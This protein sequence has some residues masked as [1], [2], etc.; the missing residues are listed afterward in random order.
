MVRSIPRRCGAALLATAVTGLLAVVDP[1]PAAAVVTAGDV[2]D[3][4]IYIFEADRQE[5]IR[6]GPDGT[7]AIIGTGLLNS[8]GQ[9]FDVGPDGAVYSTATNFNR[10]ETLAPNGTTVPVP[11]V[12]ALTS[13]QSVGVDD[14]GAVYVTR[15]GNGTVVKRAADGTES[16]FSLPVALAFDAAV[17]GDGS[18]YMINRFN[19]SLVM[20]TPSGVVS[21]VA[22][23]AQIPNASAVAV[24]DGGVIYLGAYTGQIYRVTLGAGPTTFE[25]LATGLGY[26]NDISVTGDGHVYASRDADDVVE[27]NGDGSVTQVLTGFDRPVGLVVR[28]VPS[29][30]SS[31]TATPGSAS[32]DVSWD[33]GQTNGGRPIVRYTAVSDPGGLTCTPL[34]PTDT[35]CTVTGLT[36]GVQY[37]FKVTASNTMTTAGESLLSGASNAVTPGLPEA[38]T[39]FQATPGDTTADVSFVPGSPGGD[40][41]QTWET[42]ID[43]EVSWQPLVTQPGAGGTLTG[44]VSS[45]P[46]GVTSTILLRGRTSIGPGPAATTTVI[47]TSPSPSPSP[48][49]TSPSPS[50]SSTSPSPSP[51]TTSP[52]TTPPT[53]TPPT[54]TPPTTQPPTTAP[55]TTP[56]PTTPPTTAP[57]T[58]PPTS[59]TPTPT[60]STPAPTRPNAPTGVTA[61]AGTSSVL[62]SWQPPADNGV[63]ITGYRAV[64]VPGPASCTTNGATSCILGGTA[65]VSYRVMVVAT[66]ASGNS[67]AS[68]YSNTAIPTA[69]TVATTPPA[70]NVPLDTDQGQITT[71]TPGQSLTLVGSGYAPYS[72]VT[73]T[74]YSEPIVLATV[75]TDKNGAFSQAVTVPADLASGKHSF[76]ATGVNP[77]GKPR[78]MRMDV[79]VQHEPSNLP[80]TGSAV[81]W[82]L[83]TGL[84]M[85]TAGAGLRLVKPIRQSR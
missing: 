28:T 70:T 35:Q 71:T 10:V 7:S 2:S 38:P 58:T 43:N 67:P 59:A 37:T 32:A 16:T 6:V 30:P 53:T 18:V 84:S 63:T 78:A 15:L 22:T 9:G 73:L 83:V 74:L 60:S 25:V 41:N 75:V 17:G 42:S 77:R 49:S 80:V 79:T 56:A 36:D 76:T 72:T 23:G 81:M 51:S 31:V 13:P 62:V 55:P 5:V 61:T 44:T 54:T 21:T 69:P 46:N 1:R 29:P 3:R 47:A 39:S 33:T 66:S 40:P 64:A 34:V 48:S 4:A 8:G 85:T 82:L 19:G 27:L 24:D 52:S 57:T 50:P 45:L 14:S 68:A 26:I 11:F 65:G 12:T 20:R